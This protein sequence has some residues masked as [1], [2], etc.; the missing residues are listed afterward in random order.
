MDCSPLG[1]SVHGIL[2]ERILE[3]VAMPSNQDIF[4]TQ[5]STL[6]PELQADSLPTEPPGKP[7]YMRLTHIS[8]FF[9]TI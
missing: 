1:F 5:G 2:Q 8:L 3:W 4:P 7:I 9:S 6:I